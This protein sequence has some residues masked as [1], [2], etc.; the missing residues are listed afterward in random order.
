MNAIGRTKVAG[1]TE[2]DSQNYRRL[3]FDGTGTVYNTFKDCSTYLVSVSGAAKTSATAT[4]TAIQIM[5][6]F[7]EKYKCSGVCNPALWYY[8]LEL[9]YGIPVNNCLI[10]LKQEIGSNLIY[11]GIT[12]L[13]TG[14]VLFVVWMFQYCL[15]RKFK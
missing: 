14:F 15:W 5:T 10:Y 6:Y 13:V 3:F 2:F 7:E 9:S 1:T 12:S 11:L 8:S 4:S